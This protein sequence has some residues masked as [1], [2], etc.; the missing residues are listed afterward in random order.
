M[1]R[2]RIDLAFS[3]LK[4]YNYLGEKLLHDGTQLIGKALHI[5]PQAWLHCIYPPLN[6]D[7]IAVLEKELNQQIPDVY[8][9]FLRISN[10][11][12]VFNTTLS[13]FG[14]R[15]NYRRSADDVWQPF[16]IVRSNTI[17]KPKNASENIFIIGCY[18]WDG[19]YLYIDANDSSIHLCETD[20]VK[21][22][23]E[24]KSFEDMLYSE[25]NRLTNLFDA[26]GKE[27]DDEQ[28]MLPF[29]EFKL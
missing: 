22:L 3:T 9:Q 13:L 7:D 19:S 8:K 21:S 6:S 23:Y 14:R 17:E 27:I 12:S 11:L 25:V 18:D 16:D 2:E 28:S 10:G 29:S 26:N 4:R 24:W 1:N 20:D 15:C 5:A